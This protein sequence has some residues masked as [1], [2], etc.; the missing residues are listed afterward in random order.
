MLNL[1]KGTP[2]EPLGNIIEFL[3]HSNSSTDEVKEIAKKEIC[4]N[5]KMRRDIT[6]DII[7][8]YKFYV[9]P[10]ILLTVSQLFFDY[11]RINMVIEDLKELATPLTTALLGI[12]G[13][14]FFTNMVNSFRGK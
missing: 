6:K 11:D 4:P 1:F 13:P 5:T 10:M 3:N 14:S 2:I 7:S 8:L 9:I 12:I